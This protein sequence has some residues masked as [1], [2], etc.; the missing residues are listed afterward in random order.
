MASLFIF[1]VLNQLSSNLEH[2]SISISLSVA[3]NTCAINLA[4]QKF[5]FKGIKNVCQR[6]NMMSICV[7]FMQVMIIT[8]YNMNLLVQSIFKLRMLINSNTTGLFTN[9]NLFLNKWN[10]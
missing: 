6:K 1:E 7:H 5:I 8:Y 2:Q 3:S 4:V 10:I 9:F